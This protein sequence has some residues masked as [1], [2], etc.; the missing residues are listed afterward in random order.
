MNSWLPLHIHSMIHE[1]ASRLDT[2]LAYRLWHHQNGVM[3]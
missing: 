2:S 3:I 1:H